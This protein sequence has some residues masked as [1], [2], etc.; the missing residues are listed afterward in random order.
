[1]DGLELKVQR[2]R[3]RVTQWTLA[4][5]AG[6]HPARISE[7]ELGKRPVAN[8]VLEALDELTVAPL[9]ARVSRER[10][11]RGATRF[12]SCL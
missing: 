9:G 1:M 4:K 12:T 3:A 10:A 8:S 11:P 6:V 5:L 2:V 7:M